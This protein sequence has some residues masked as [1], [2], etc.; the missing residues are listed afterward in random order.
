MQIH[1]VLLVLVSFGLVHCGGTEPAPKPPVASDSS[2]SGVPDTGEVVETEA[3]PA[4]S[5]GI[6][7]DPH[8]TG[9]GEHLD[10]LHAAVAHLASVHADAPLEFVV[11]LGDIAWRDGWDDASSALDALPVP[12]VP[13]QGDNPIQVGEEQGFITAF[14]PQLDHLAAGLDGWQ[15]LPSPV[16]DPIYEQVWLTNIAFEV[17]G[18]TFVGLD[19]NSRDTETILG[20]TPDLFDVEGGTLPFLESVLEQTAATDGLA[21]RVITLTHMPMMWGPGFFTVDEVAVMESR[22][23]PYSDLLLANLAGHLHGNG[24]TEWEALD[25]DVHVT[26]APWDDENLVRVAHISKTNLRVVLELEDHI[27]ESP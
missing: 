24:S 12:W 6:I 1:R 13:I 25:M 20:E 8:V 9:E 16:D 7:A 11:V 26:D 14:G 17:D 19:W 23:G 10:R 27:V 4:F 21:G 3:V 18:V 2:D 15:H 5:F 22:I